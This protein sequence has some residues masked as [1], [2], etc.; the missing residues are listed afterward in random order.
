MPLETSTKIEIDYNWMRQIRFWVYA[1]C[2]NLLGDNI[3]TIKKT[4]TLSNASQEFGLER[5][6]DTDQYVVTKM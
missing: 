2:A 4:E 3:N 6:A 5:N 1:D